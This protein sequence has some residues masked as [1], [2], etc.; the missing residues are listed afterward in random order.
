[1]RDGRWAP[2]TI[3]GIV[4]GNLILLFIFFLMPRMQ[5]LLG[6]RGLTPS[7]LMETAGSSDIPNQLTG[8]YAVVHRVRELTPVSATVFMP[9]G[10]RMQGSF[11][12]ATIQVLYPRKVFFGED[13]NFEGELMK[14]EQSEDSY[15]VYSQ[16]WKPGF[17]GQRSRIE[18]TD[19]GFGMCRLDL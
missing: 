7:Q 4:I 14:A 5:F 11:R 12:S 18:L 10:D 6:H 2:K 13:N 15:F 17:C 19:F 1:M 9:P 16:E 3:A 8:T